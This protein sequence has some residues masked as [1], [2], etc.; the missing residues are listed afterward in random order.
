[1]ELRSRGA[2]GP[3]AHAGREK[4]GRKGALLGCLLALLLS[5]LPALAQQPSFE[6]TYRLVARKLGDGTTVNSSD[7]MGVMC[8]AHGTWSLNLAWKEDGKWG[9]HSFASSYQIV[10]DRFI[11]TLMFR[12]YIQ[13]TGAVERAFNTAGRT[14]STPIVTSGNRVTLRRVPEN[15]FEGRIMTAGIAGVFTDIW[16]RIE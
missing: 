12:V 13:P 5:G 8:I 15:V 9:S 3:R 2:V 14:I 6:G 1:M 10:G 4:I 16:E 7:F 11:E